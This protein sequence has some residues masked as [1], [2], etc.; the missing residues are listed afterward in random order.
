MCTEMNYG[1]SNMRVFTFS[2]KLGFFPEEIV[3]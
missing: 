1:V 3:V 2:V